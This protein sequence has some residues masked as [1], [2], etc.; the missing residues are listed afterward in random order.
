MQSELDTDYRVDISLSLVYIYEL[1]FYPRSVVKNKPPRKAL[2]EN[3]D[4]LSQLVV[5]L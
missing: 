3:W 2:A 1:C 5:F 4:L